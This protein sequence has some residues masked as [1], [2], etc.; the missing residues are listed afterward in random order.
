MTRQT[1]TDRDTFRPQ[2]GSSAITSEPRHRLRTPL[3]LCAVTAVAAVA[4]VCFLG[5]DTA[6]RAQPPNPTASTAGTAVAG[7]A[8]SATAWLAAGGSAELAA[9]EDDF[10]HLVNDAQSAPG[11]AMARFAQDCAHLAA[12]AADAQRSRPIPDPQAQTSWSRA[13]RLMRA[14]ADTC[15]TAAVRAD[16]VQLDR[17]LTQAASGTDD[18]HAAA[19]RFQ[20]LITP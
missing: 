13:L 16:T 9:L 17:G 3:G 15:R 18:I 6:A 5:R 2:P 14:G 11:T 8:A 20:E 7:S 4:V 19:T 12:D 1:P 10:T